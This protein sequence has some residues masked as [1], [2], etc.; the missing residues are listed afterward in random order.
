MNDSLSRY[1]PYLAMMLLFV[2][3]QTIII[4]RSNASYKSFA[5]QLSPGFTAGRFLL[6]P[7]VLCT[8]SR[9]SIK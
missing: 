1:R 4:Q 5:N 2:I 6:F 8:T 9:Y 3:I 7:Y